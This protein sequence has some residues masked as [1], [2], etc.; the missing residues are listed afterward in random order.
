MSFKKRSAG[1]QNLNGDAIQK[2][3]AGLEKSNVGFQALE[4]SPTTRQGFHY[5]PK[6]EFWNFNGA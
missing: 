1:L 5:L 3:K 4:K 6:A 2:E